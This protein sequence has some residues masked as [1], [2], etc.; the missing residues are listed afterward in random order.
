MPVECDV[1]LACVG[2]ERF[3]VIDRMVMRHAF[4]IH[5]TLGRFCDE[6]IYQEELAQRCRASGFDVHR[7]VLM[8]VSHGEFAKTY[9]LDMLVDRGFIYELKTVETLNK[10][11]EMQLINYLLL[12]DLRHGKLV[13][14]RSVS[15]QS[16]FVSTSL[17]LQD[18][19]AFQI[20][21]A[22]WQCDDRE[23][24]C[25]REYL[26][27]LLSDWGAFLEVNLYREALLHVL[28]GPE[29]GIQP[30]NIDV[31]GRTVGAQKM[32]LLNAGTAWHISSIRHHVSEYE[33][34]IVRL[35]SHTRLKRIQWINLEQRT[36][37]FKTLINNSAINDSV[38]C[39]AT[40]KEKI[41]PMSI[42]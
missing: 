26:C 23:S 11:H 22:E 25:L 6:R 30:V 5:N 19:R 28:G 14:F 24:R 27:A 29:A 4:D 13:N 21:D 34:H 1:E 38:I 2:Q 32:C 15:V 36:V 9:Y 20:N 3:H 17:K 8:R 33:K 18:R 40:T 16:R 39:E 7:E 10:N 35:L 12:A 37:K 41:W 42:F 31:N